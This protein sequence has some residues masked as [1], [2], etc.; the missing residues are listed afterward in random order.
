MSG[1]HA[2]S[3]GAV[4]F[5]WEAKQRWRAGAPWV[6]RPG[7]LDSSEPGSPDGTVG[8]AAIGKFSVVSLAGNGY[9][10][11]T[12]LRGRNG[13]APGWSITGRGLLA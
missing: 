4:D 10:N 1:F 8:S 13:T 11:D 9:L 12:G 2:S 7:Q 5:M 6:G 3:D